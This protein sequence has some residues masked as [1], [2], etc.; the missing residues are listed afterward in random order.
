VQFYV[1]WTSALICNG[2]IRLKLNTLWTYNN[3]DV[4]LDNII[5]STELGDALTIYDTNTHEQSTFSIQS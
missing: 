1:K 4:I 5:Y 2:N 3:D